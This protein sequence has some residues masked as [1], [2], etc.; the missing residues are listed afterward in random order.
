MTGTGTDSTGKLRRTGGVSCR[1]PCGAVVAQL[2]CSRVAEVAKSNLLGKYF[3]TPSHSISR[4]F[5]GQ[6][7]VKNACFYKLVEYCGGSADPAKVKGRFWR[8]LPRVPPKFGHN[9]LVQLSEWQMLLENGRPFVVPRSAVRWE[10]VRR[11]LNC[12]IARDLVR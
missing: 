11:K 7:A 4:S 5:L 6:V 9:R 3:P 8:A 2:R 10:S 1:T 12:L